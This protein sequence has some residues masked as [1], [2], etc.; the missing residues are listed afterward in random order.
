LPVIE[1]VRGKVV[2]GTDRERPPLPEIASWLSGE[3]MTS[4]KSAVKR[5]SLTEKN[6]RR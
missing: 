5:R 6:S 2:S 1:M 4:V 3:T